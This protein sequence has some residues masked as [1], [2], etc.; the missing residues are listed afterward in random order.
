[1]TIVEDIENK[2]RK[3]KETKD[4]DS[5]IEAIDIL[6]QFVIQHTHKYSEPSGDVYV[7]DYIRST[8]EP[9]HDI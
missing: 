6:F 9:D 4:I 2:I 7:P 5:A 8:T 1:M 3:A